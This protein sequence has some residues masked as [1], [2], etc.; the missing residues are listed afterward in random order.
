MKYLY[1][2]LILIISLF[3]I[4]NSIST[5]ILLSLLSQRYYSFDNLLN[6][7]DVPLNENKTIEE[8]EIEEAES[9]RGKLFSLLRKYVRSIN[10]SQSDVSISCQNVINKYLF[11]QIDEK[12][13]SNISYIISDYNI[14]KLLD[15]SSKN[16]NN[17]GSYDGCMKR[18]Y[19]MKTVY[20]KVLSKYNKY[21]Y[22]LEKSTLSTYFVVQVEKNNT[23]KTTDEGDILNLDFDF[24]LQAYCLPQGYNEKEYC[25]DEDYLNLLNY[26]NDK[27]DNILRF[28][29]TH[30]DTF[31]LR[32]NPYKGKEDFTNLKIFLQ[33]LPALYFILQA[34]F[35]VFRYVIITIIQSLNNCYDNRKSKNKNKDIKK[36]EENNEEDENDDEEER[37]SVKNEF[38]ARK[39]TNKFIIKDEILKCFSLIENAEELFNFSINSTKFNNDSGLNYIRGLMG[40]SMIFIAIGFTFI[41][42]YNSPI[43][44]SSPGHIIEFFDKNVVLGVMVMI[45]IRYSPRVLLSCSGYLLAY[46]Y[47]S[48]LNKNINRTTEPILKPFAKFLSYQVHKYFLLIMLFLFERYSAY[49]LYNFFNTQENPA[50]KYLYKYILKKPSD[51]RYLLSF[52]L[53]GNIHYNKDEQ[54]RRGSNL[55]HYLW[56]P[57][58]EILFFLIGVIFITIGFKTRWRIDIIIIVL[59]PFIYIAKTIYF[60][61]SS[62]YYKDKDFPLN[63]CYSTLYYVFFNYGRDM[64]NPLF[65]LPYYFIGIYFGIIN[66][67]IQKGIVSLYKSDNIRLFLSK[68][69]LEDMKIE[70]EESD[71]NS[72]SDKLFPD[73]PEEKKQNPN[74]NINYNKKVE[75]CEEVE[76]MPFLITPIIFVQWHRKTS[77]KFLYILCFIF[78]VLFFFFSYIILIFSTGNDVEKREEKLKKAFVNDFINFIY[79]IDIE[80]VIY[81][82]LW[83]SFIIMIQMNDLAFEFFNNIFWIVLS[84]PYYSFILVINTLL[85]FVFYHEETLNEVHPISILMFSLIGGGLTFIC[86]SLF[87]IFYELPLK[88]VIRLFYKNYNDINDDES[89]EKSEK[90]YSENDDDTSDRDNKIKED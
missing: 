38:L 25:S 65:N 35:I 64:I 90:N 52:L 55:L 26:T 58:T 39:K 67:T 17:L 50:F 6:S 14:V 77:K 53:W 44:E 20:N 79:R 41:T 88:R 5:N 56:L 62:D 18:S 9:Y 81:F 68:E 54:Y 34:G 45:G 69:E 11:G 13:S 24:I 78:I 2:S 85:L 23:N 51:S 37:L 72:N 4:N 82:V 74:I 32:V 75:Y 8:L 36:N 80:L 19:K 3:L 21:G 16:R 28:H 84:R 43:K 31:S 15:D 71:D 83:F 60:Y 48:Y 86:M 70:D 61:L 10:I 1:L 12:N 46:K 7:P 59:V 29:N 40:L 42:L 30:L 27:L 33:I 22:D 76:K 66:F 87:Y 47:I 57:F 73:V 89:E 63:K 49:H